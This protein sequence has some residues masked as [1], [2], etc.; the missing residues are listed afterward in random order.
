[1]LS[2]YVEGPAG[3]V[4]LVGGPNRR[5]GEKPTFDD[6]ATTDLVAWASCK[7]QFNVHCHVKSFVDTKLSPH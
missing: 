6:S 3:V 4:T 1:M 2:M 7:L 5:E